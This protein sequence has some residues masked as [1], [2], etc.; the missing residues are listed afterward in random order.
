MEHN[1]SE[2]WLDDFDFEDDVSDNAINTNLIKLAMARRAISN[3]VHILTNKPIPVYF[4][5]NGDNSTCGQ[6]VYISSDIVNKEDFD[7]AVGLALHEGSHVLLSDFDIFKTI[8]QKVPRELY[9]YGQRLQISKED[10]HMLVKNI[11]NYVEDRY[12]DN[13]VFKNA[14]GYRGY[15]N[16][17]YDTYFHSSKI[18][19]MLKSDLYRVPSIA[20]YEARIINFTNK[21]TD[22]DAL[23]GLREIAKI[24]NLS[25]IDRLKTTYDRLQVAYEVVSIILQNIIEAP[26]KNEKGQSQNIGESDESQGGDSSESSKIPL[27]NNGQSSNGSPSNLNQ[28]TDDV[29]GGDDTTKVSTTDEQTVKDNIGED[30]KVSKTRTNQIKKSLDKQKDFLNGNIKKKK[31]STKEKNILDAIEKSGMTLVSVGNTYIKSD[32]KYKVDCIV[33]K[34]LTKEL[35]DSKL[36][37]LSMIDYKDKAYASKEMVNAINEGFVKGSVLGRKLQIRNEINTC[38]HMRKSTGR[39]DKRIL[40]ELSYD[41][42]N[43]FYNIDVDR[44]NK[45]YIHISVDASSSMG[46]NK[47]LTTMT[48]VT[49]ICKAASMIDNVRV[50]VSFRSTFGAGRSSEHPYVVIAYDSNTDKISKVKN[51]F[52]YIVPAGC[53]PEGMCFESIMNELPTSTDDNYYFLNFSDG[54]PYMNYQDVSGVAVQYGGEQACIHTRNQVNKIR[55]KGYKI[56]SYF[57]KEEYESLY[58]SYIIN[59]VNKELDNVRKQFKVMYGQN[60]SFVNVKNIFDIAKTINKMFLNKD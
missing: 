6:T 54:Q 49:A 29:L 4:N 20:S 34:K 11:L 21:N 40:S 23:P 27:D 1:Y 47:W 39:I 51:L 42:E 8:W 31:V 48:A 14:P 28:N 38:K 44:Y 9:T 33:V 35:I 17:L 18:D 58:N 22:L 50:T 15:Y 10:I 5:D 3:F 25:D 53:T 36:F 37:P 41:N 2:Y 24:I 52:P 12:I 26:K 13:Y 60:A 30:S 32:G 46:G 57:I 16:A 59:S 56:L 7:P 19:I 43:V 55:D 45:S